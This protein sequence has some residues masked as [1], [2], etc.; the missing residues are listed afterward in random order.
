MSD[1]N[2]GSN[3][4]SRPQI[5]PTIVP[6]RLGPD[7]V[8]FRAGPWSG[9]ILTLSDED[10]EGKLAEVIAHLD[11]IQTLE[12]I[13]ETFDDEDEPTIRHL[14]QKLAKQ[15]I[16]FDA[17]ETGDADRTDRSP[18]PMRFSAS[19]SE[20]LASQSVLVVSA[21]EIGSHLVSMLA[22]AGIREITVR[23]R[24]QQPFDQNVSA[25][26]FDPETDSFRDEMAAADMV[27]CAVQDPWPAAIERTNV[28]AHETETPSATLRWSGS[29][30]PLGRQ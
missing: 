28:L 7:E 5:D 27:V 4:R 6:V 8:H 30:S 15:N 13:L 3:R 19:D 12:S 22:E 18:L 2:G 25:S 17:S 1:W 23:H 26:A 10:R 24:G 11:G 20:S 9:P 21:G 14:I 29:I 16:L